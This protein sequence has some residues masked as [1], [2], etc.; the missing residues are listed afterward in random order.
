METIDVRILKAGCGKY[1]TNGEIIC[2]VIQLAKSANEL[3]WREITEVEKEELE[4]RLEEDA[5]REFAK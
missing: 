5:Q 2:K 1:L 3:D 4:R